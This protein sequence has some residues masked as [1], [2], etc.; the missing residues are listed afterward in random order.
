MHT[1][2][3]FI[4]A[5]KHVKVTNTNGKYVSGGGGALMQAISTVFFSCSPKIMNLTWN[6]PE[7]LM[8]VNK[9]TVFWDII[10]CTVVKLYHSTIGTVTKL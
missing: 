7:V 1:D 5:G 9:I 8:T 6:N 10:K 4:C 2:K 3:Q